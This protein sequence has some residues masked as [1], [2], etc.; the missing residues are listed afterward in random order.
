MTD[1][2]FDSRLSDVVERL[3]V[4]ICVNSRLLLSTLNH[5]E[6][7]LSPP[8]L[9]QSPLSNV[10]KPPH[11]PLSVS[12]ETDVLFSRRMFSPMI[13]SS[14]KGKG[15]GRALPSPE[16]IP[17]APALAAYNTFLHT[18]VQPA[19]N[20]EPCHC[21]LCLRDAGTSAGSSNASSSTAASPFSPTSTAVSTPP[22]TPESPGE[23]PDIEMS[24]PSD[25]V[26]PVV[27]APGNSQQHTGYSLAGAQP[28]NMA[29]PVQHLY[30]A[31]SASSSGAAWTSASQSFSC[32]ATTHAHHLV[33]P[34]FVG[35]KRCREDE[36]ESQGGPDAKRFHGRY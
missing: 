28:A 30:P 23:S 9:D 15:K 26:G 10:G 22:L 34:P 19:I 12:L 33:G 17:S 1:G 29:G 13:S 16:N 32:A 35:G 3:V 24:P 20:S 7:A 4:D 21:S 2:P 25:P 14:S 36:D 31:Q 5:D 8:I 11:L 6:P 18:G 27:G